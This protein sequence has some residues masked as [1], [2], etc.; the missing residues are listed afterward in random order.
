MRLRHLNE[1]G[2]LLLLCA[3]CHSSFDEQP[4]IWTF[5]PANLDAFIAH[6]KAYQRSCEA[7][8][9]SGGDRPVREALYPPNTPVEYERYLVRAGFI[10]PTPF[11]QHP[12]KT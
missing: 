11:I 2:N 5:L 9:G 4:P 7:A 10:P 3:G 8:A 1:P 12:R 6:E